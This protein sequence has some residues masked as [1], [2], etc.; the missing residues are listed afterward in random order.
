R[1]NL[2]V[3]LESALDMA[4]RL[5][6]VSVAEGIETMDDWRLLQR[7]GCTVG[8]GYS[9]TKPM[10]ASEMPQWLR[11]HK[12]RLPQLRAAAVAA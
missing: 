8:E 3:I 9:I 10:P 6:L 7:Y 11:S 12:L 5:E 2:S 4:R 1:R